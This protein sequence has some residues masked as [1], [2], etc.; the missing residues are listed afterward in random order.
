M[1]FA[2]KYPH[3]MSKYFK[4]KQTNKQKKKTKLGTFSSTEALYYAA[5]TVSIVIT[6][7]CCTALPVVNIL[8][9]GIVSQYC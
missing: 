7:Y 4:A 8:T 2:H 9:V 6:Y 3:N 5:I 1:V